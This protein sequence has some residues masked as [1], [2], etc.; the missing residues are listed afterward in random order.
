[1]AE[2]AVQHRGSAQDFGFRVMKLGLA[3]KGAYLLAIDSRSASGL[4]SVLGSVLP[5]CKQYRDV[6]LSWTQSKSSETAQESLSQMTNAVIISL[7][8]HTRAL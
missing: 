5:G 6:G 1:M 2:A 8:K 7:E 4:I 3:S